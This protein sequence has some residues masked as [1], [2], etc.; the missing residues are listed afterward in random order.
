MR[1]RLPRAQRAATLLLLGTAL[2][3]A[4]QQNGKSAPVPAPA[5]RL[6]EAQRREAESDRAERA[7]ALAP[8]PAP[9]FTPPPAAQPAAASP[10]PPASLSAPAPAAVTAPRA[11]PPPLTEEQI[12]NTALTQ[13]QVRS[14]PAA[15]QTLTEFSRLFPNSR[16]RPNAAF[17]QAEIDFLE[18]HWSL[19]REG[20]LG[21]TKNFPDH[22][23]AADSLYKAALCSLKMSDKP[24]A[25]GLLSDVLRRFPASE[26]ALLAE[27]KLAELTKRT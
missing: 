1:L 3:G 25:I 14:L 6:A 2:A 9:V 21:V 7:A 17:W 13:I 27:K 18:E 15:R 4:A 10:A 12:Y 5:D 8:L 20:F 22:P 16:R 24:S 23:K 11:Q 19:A 26:A